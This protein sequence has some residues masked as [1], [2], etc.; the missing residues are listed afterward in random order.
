MARRDPDEMRNKA[1][2]LR[3]AGGQRVTTDAWEIGADLLEALEE[4]I[5]IQRE[6]GAAIK[7]SSPAK[8]KRGS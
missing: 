4:L 3:F 2:Q 6:V 7:W 1:A 8:P 5:E